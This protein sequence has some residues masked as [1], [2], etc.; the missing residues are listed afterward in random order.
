VALHDAAGDRAGAMEIITREIVRVRQSLATDPLDARLLARVGLFL[1][2][3]RERGVGDPIADAEAPIASLLGLLG[4]RPATVPEVPPRFAPSSA[5]ALFAEAMQ[6]AAGGFIAEVWPNLLE[7]AGALFPA[8]PRERRAIPAPGWIASAA[9]A[10]GLGELATFAGRD[11]DAA[12]VVPIEEPGPGLVLAP[13]AEADPGLGFLVGRGLG[14]LVQRATLLE[15]ASPDDLAPLFACAA[16]VAGA[17]PPRGLPKPSEEMLRTVTRALGR[18]PRKA[19]ALQ[20]SRF[21]FEIFDVRAWHEAVLR[22]ADRLGLL[23]AGDVAAS[24]VALARLRRTT[25]SGGDPNAAPSPAVLV[26]TS[27]VAL[28]LVRFAVGDRYPALRR[29]ALGADVSPGPGGR[30]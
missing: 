6:P 8:P 1:T 14:L 9:A 29:A 30:G 4:E 15:R 21:E 18:K 17:S 5:R 23:V 22:T 10:L 26:A 19:L 11:A 13:G 7:A 24:A 3:A 16:I 27:G 2:F 12:L 20:A 28:E 25:K